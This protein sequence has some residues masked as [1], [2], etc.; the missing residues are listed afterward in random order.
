M[1]LARIVIGHGSISG[2]D[3]SEN[4][5]IEFPSSILHQIQENRSTRCRCVD[6][7]ETEFSILLM[8]TQTA[9]TQIDTAANKYNFDL[10]VQ[11]TR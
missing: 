8:L 3:V 9:L 6:S 4:K 10:Y 7:I 1:H 11:D 2:N 5:L